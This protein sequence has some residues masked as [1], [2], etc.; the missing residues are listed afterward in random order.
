MICTMLLYPRKEG[1][2]L[3]IT[4]LGLRHR[5]LS[6]AIFLLSSLFMTPYTLSIT[7]FNPV[8]L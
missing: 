6:N 7:E 3:M 4:I 1:V 2:S 8:S 5:I